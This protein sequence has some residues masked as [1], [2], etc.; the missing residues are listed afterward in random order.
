MGYAKIGP[1]WWGGR[2]VLGWVG[3]DE[4][5]GLGE[6]RGG[7]RLGSSGWERQEVSLVG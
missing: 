1:D 3:R 4:K 5:L 2:V 7:V 6:A